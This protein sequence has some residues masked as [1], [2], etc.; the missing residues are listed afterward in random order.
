M[1]ACVEHLASYGD[2]M[3]YDRKFGTR[4]DGQNIT[5]YELTSREG[6]KAVVL[7]QGAILQALY[8]PNGQNITLGF[9]TWP[10]YEA[11]QSYCG[12]FIGPN[13]NRIVN[14]KFEIDENTYDLEAN[15]GANNL[16]SWPKGLDS[17]LWKVQREKSGLELTHS[18]PDG[19]NGFP[20][21]VDV[22]LRISLNKNVLR[23]E[24]EATT[25]RPTPINM[26]WHP[27][28]N[29]NGNGRIDG[30]DLQVSANQRTEIGSVAPIALRDTRFDF[31]K[32]LPLGGVKIDDNYINVN[33]VKLATKRVSLEV[34]S[35]LPDM[36]IYTG[37]HLPDPR[38]GIAVEP[39]F[40]PN[41]IN[42]DKHS[43][44]RPG[45]TYRH[46]TEYKFD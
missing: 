14:A 22:S 34:T 36:Q 1:I 25:S 2:C 6:F 3:T 23:I 31:Q 10:E 29:L 33:S 19:H 37:D 11:D 13:A 4:K 42:L 30:H 12:R 40:R 27:Y 16:H 32:S 28:W 35:S 45:Q 44:L 43:L 26:T 46:W 17:A 15:D 41:D 24:K 20:G 7:D 18:S 8:L 9:E 38:H 39:Q 5:A 21:K